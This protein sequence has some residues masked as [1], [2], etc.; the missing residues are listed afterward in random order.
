MTAT[1]K[2]AKSSTKQDPLSMPRHP[3]ID[4][5]TCSIESCQKEAYELVQER[6]N[7]KFQEINRLFQMVHSKQAT[8]P[9]K[10]AAVLWKF[11]SELDACVDNMEDIYYNYFLKN[12]K[13]DTLVN[14]MEESISV[15]K[16]TMNAFL[17][18][19]IMF[20]LMSSDEKH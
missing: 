11:E 19:M 18:Y 2:R 14:E 7:E 20:N 4:M 10:Y 6:L 9:C 17:P 13:Q 8:A 3:S 15:T 12:K 5:S 16:K 1:G